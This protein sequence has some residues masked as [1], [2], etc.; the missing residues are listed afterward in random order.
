MVSV[1]FRIEGLNRVQRMLNRLPGDIDQAKRDILVELGRETKKST[2][3]RI[4]GSGAVHKSNL[5]KDVGL[6]LSRLEDGVVSVGYM[7]RHALNV[8]GGSYAKYQEFGFKKHRV[9]FEEIRDWYR[10]K[11]GGKEPPF[12]TVSKPIRGEGYYLFPASRTIGRKVNDI[13][14]RYVNKA[15]KRSSGGA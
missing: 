12:V 2:I 8:E 11:V 7:G 3:L 6:D 15:I 10:A 13:A 14:Y 9:P 4:R 1:S 5:I